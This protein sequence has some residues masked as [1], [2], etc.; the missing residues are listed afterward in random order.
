MI[1]PRT[2]KTYVVARL[3]AFRNQETLEPSKQKRNAEKRTNSEPA[4]Q[5]HR[6]LHDSEGNREIR[7]DEIRARAKVGG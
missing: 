3:I 6:E 4:L 5:F 2:W 7:T 1:S